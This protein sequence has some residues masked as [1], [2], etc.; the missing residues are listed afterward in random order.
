MKLAAA[1]A[2]L[3]IASCCVFGCGT[4]VT[5]EGSD[6]VVGKV[7]AKIESD[8]LC[9]ETGWLVA[10]HSFNH[11]G[12][13]CEQKR[14][15]CL[16]ACDARLKKCKEGWAFEHGECTARCDELRVDCMVGGAGQP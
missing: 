4:D 5:E 6:E 15:K 11:A 3:V 16:D 12:G 7:A 2:A 14:I 13:D 9:L 8:P 1:A 10:G